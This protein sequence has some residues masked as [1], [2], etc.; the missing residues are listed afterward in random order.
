MQQVSLPPPDLLC[1]LCQCSD[2]WR[3]LKE[4]GEELKNLPTAPLTWSAMIQLEAQLLAPLREKFGELR[5]T[6]GFAGPDLVS[7][8][9]KRAREEGRHANINPTTDQ[10]AGHEL[11]RSNQRMCRRDGFAVD[12]ICPAHASTAVVRW[13]VDEAL[14]FDRI[15]V[16]DDARPFHLSWSEDPVGMVVEMRKY[17]N[18]RLVPRVVRRGR[19]GKPG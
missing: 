6:Y 1:M 14:A 5:L 15:Y 3:A 19:G 18:G 9:R 17:P 16:Y 8:I 4:R 12:L 11:N 13:L 7:A 2:T 10:H